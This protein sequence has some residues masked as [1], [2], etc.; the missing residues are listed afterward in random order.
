MFARTLLGCS[1]ALALGA[2]PLVQAQTAEPVDQA[3]P[4][5]LTLKLDLTD[6]PKRIFRITET[7][8]VKPGALTLYYPKWIP[9]E[10]IPSGPI[11][12][13]S[14]LII[15]ANGKQLPWRRDLRDMA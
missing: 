1:V 9:G 10:H 15:T 12:N 14:G 2:V 13:V 8:P 11:N 6:A 3:Y 7:I 5:T 4:G